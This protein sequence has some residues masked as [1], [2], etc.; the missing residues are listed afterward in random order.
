MIHLKVAYKYDFHKDF[1]EMC[2]TKMDVMFIPTGSYPDDWY[3]GSGENR[4][5]V[6]SS[7]ASEKDRTGTWWVRL[8]YKR[9]WLW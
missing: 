3:P 1:Q 2:L 7:T 6:L 9:V 5:P 8:C 4:A